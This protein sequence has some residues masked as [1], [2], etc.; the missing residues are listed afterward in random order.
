MQGSQKQDLKD[1]EVQ[2]TQQKA[3]QYLLCPGKVAVKVENDFPVSKIRIFFDRPWKKTKKN[4]ATRRSIANQHS[5]YLYHPPSASQSNLNPSRQAFDS[6]I[7]I[8]FVSSPQL[9]S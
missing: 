8:L 3:S 5:K 2:N 4:H 6:F 7:D 9:Y 1:F